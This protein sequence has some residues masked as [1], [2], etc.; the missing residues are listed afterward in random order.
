MDYKSDS[1]LPMIQKEIQRQLEPLKNL[2]PQQ[3][4]DMFA[5]TP[6][7]RK[8]LVDQDNRA[9]IDYLS[10]SPSVSSGSVKNTDVYKDIVKRMKS[11]IESN[12]KV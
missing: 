1:I 7:Q 9:K 6:D 3:E 10:R 12:Y 4:N 8:F 11:R 5:L 2:N